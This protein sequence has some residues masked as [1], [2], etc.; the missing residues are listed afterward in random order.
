[1][2]VRFNNFFKV[3]SLLLAT[4]SFTNGIG[5]SANKKEIAV[6][7]FKK[8]QKFG[9]LI[10]GDILYTYNETNAVDFNSPNQKASDIGVDYNFY[11]IHN[12]NFKASFIWRQYNIKETS[13]FKGEDI[14]Y[15]QDITSKIEWGPF[16]QFKIPIAV[17]YY[18]PLTQKISA[19][20][21]LGP[22]FIIYPEDPTSGS[23]F[24]VLSDGTEVG[25]TEVGNSKD[26]WLYFGV[27]TS[28]GF[29][30]DTKAMLIRPFVTY[31]FQPE[32]LYT[33]VV[34]TQN[35]LVS[36]NTVSVHEIK[37]NYLMVGVSLN[38][39]RDLFKKKPK[40]Q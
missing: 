16:E 35:L 30:I 17:E 26:G 11:Q 15:S 6:D 31:H 37:G 3:A 12:F 32:V 8:H 1:M 40:K 4:F 27:N 39:S 14:N 18:F 23:S 38:P 19:Y 9:L 13:T 24:A 33:N 10:G 20:I 28:L 25:Y 2:M 5:Q 29:S 21:S 34:T 36:N 7:L 22:E